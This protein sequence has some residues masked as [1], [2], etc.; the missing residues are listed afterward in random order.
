MNFVLVLSLVLG[1]PSAVSAASLLSPK[2]LKKAPLMSS[3]EKLKG[4]TGI[5][6]GLWICADKAKTTLTAKCD[7]HPA[8]EFDEAKGLLELLAVTPIGK[9]D[10]GLRHAVQTSE[11]RKMLRAI[12][13][14]QKR[15][16]PYCI[17][18]HYVGEIPDAAGSTKPRINAVFY[19][20]KSPLGYVI[21]LDFD[22]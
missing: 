5:M 14:V 13:K 21:D 4:P 12:K 6:S 7:E 1:A 11:C 20:L 10:Y 16:L 8:E 15:N 18:G 17:L 2:D 22:D 19:Q 9:F 3:I